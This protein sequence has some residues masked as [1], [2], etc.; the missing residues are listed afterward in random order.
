MVWISKGGPGGAEGVTEKEDVDVVVAVAIAL[1][2][3]SITL[4]RWFRVKLRLF[5]RITGFKLLVLLFDDC[6]ELG[7]CMPLAEDLHFLKL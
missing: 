6:L 4:A 5:K 2:V 7:D 3:F 1:R